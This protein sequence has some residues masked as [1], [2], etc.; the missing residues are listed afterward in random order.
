MS[1]TCVDSF[2]YSTR[3][4]C[5]PTMLQTPVLGTRET[6][7]ASAQGCL[8]PRPGAPALTGPGSSCGRVSR[9]GRPTANQQPES[10]PAT[11]N[12]CS[13]PP[14]GSQANGG[15]TLS[16]SQEAGNLEV[17]LLIFKCRPL[18]QKISLSWELKHRERTIHGWRR[19]PVSLGRGGGD[20]TE[21]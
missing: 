4:Y 6:D 12:L 15:R 1:E 21:G 7:T 2:I 16:L 19:K 14:G 5:V 3:S 11:G 8:L 10:T 20:P 13:A 18:I 9:A 17:T